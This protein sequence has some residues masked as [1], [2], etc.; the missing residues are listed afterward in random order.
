MDSRGVSGVNDKGAGLFLS[1]DA[2][3]G[4]PATAVSGGDENPPTSGRGEVGESGETDGRDIMGTG[5]VI[6]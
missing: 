5:G 6:I 4:F 3:E 2:P 1:D